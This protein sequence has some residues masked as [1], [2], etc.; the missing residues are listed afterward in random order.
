MEV[1]ARA[2]TSQG[3]WHK[4]KESVGSLVRA[5]AG[6]QWRQQPTTGHPRPT[7]HPPI[8][9]PTP[10]TYAGNGGQGR[11]VDEPQ[12]VVPR[13]EARRDELPHLGRAQR[14]GAPHHVVGHAGLKVVRK[15]LHH[16]VVGVGCGRGRAG[17]GGAGRGGAGRPPDP[18][19]A[20][21]QRAR[22]LARHLTSGSAPAGLGTSTAAS[23][24]S[25]RGCG[26]VVGGRGGGGERGQ[27][28]R[29]ARVGAC[30]PATIR[31]PRPPSPPPSSPSA[32]SLG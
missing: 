7:I 25:A 31:H 21:P 6:A 23:R 11:W 26:I 16:A 29:E 19:P 17:Q 15:I 5:N 9:P 32:F 2:G 28:G 18:T 8:H 10:P 1:V 27:Q 4:S 14:A 12:R 20:T 13:A 24:P 22:T 3:W 30:P